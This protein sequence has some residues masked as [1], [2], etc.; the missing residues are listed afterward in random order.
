M[1]RRRFVGSGACGLL[2]LPLVANA[3]PGEKIA[4][5]GF[6]AAS[7]RDRQQN[8]L[9]TMGERL[10]ELGYVEGRN[11][12]IDYRHAETEE[13]FRELATELVATGSQVIFAQ[14][15]YALRGARAASAIVPIVGLDNESDPV[16]AGYAANSRDPAAT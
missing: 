15:P 5:L 2:L 14:G 13:R 1:D 3:Q 8:V 10:H 11:L 9:S 16:A 6:L 4:R 7:P 12:V